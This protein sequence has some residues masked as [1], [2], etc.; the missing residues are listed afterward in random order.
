MTQGLWMG[1]ESP[2]L[3]TMDTDTRGV[4]QLIGSA[5]AWHAQS[6]GGVATRHKLGVV[7]EYTYNPSFGS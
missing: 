6:P 4:V 7:V 2:G 3:S 5:L 1:T